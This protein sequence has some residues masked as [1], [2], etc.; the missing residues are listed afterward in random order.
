METTH[1]LKTFSD[2]NLIMR[3]G[4]LARDASDGD[5]VALS[6]T[7]VTCPGCLAAIAQDE[8]DARKP[9]RE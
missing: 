7:S 8:I 6:P 9:T 4:L 5:F 3:C 2:H 1:A